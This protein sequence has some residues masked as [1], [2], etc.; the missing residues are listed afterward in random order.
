MST[1]LA[2]G[3][4]ILA[5]GGEKPVPFQQ[6]IC[7]SQALEP[8]IAGTFTRDAMKALVD[9]VGCNTEDLQSPATIA[10]L[11]QLDTQTLLNAS[12]ATYQSDIAHNIGD[13]WLPAIDGD[14]LPAAPSQLV[15]EHRFAK[16]V[17]TMMGWCEDDL[18]FFTDASIQ[19]AEDTRNFISMY[20]GGVT[21]AN[22]DTL[23]DLYPVSDFAAGPGSDPDKTLSAEFYRAARIFRDILMVCEPLWYGEH[24]AEAGSKVYFYDWNQTMLEPILESLTGVSGYGPIHTSEFA[25]IFGNLSHYDANGY[26]FH[27]TEADYKLRDRGSRS[28]TTFA[29]TGKPGLCVKDTFEGFKPAFRGGDNDPGLFVVGGPHEGFSQVDGPGSHE[30]VRRQRLRERCAF[31]NSPEMIEQLGV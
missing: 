11:R 2:V 3:L 26:P 12:I 7:E 28:W 14:F 6:G 18:T 24:L 31:I 29:S 10:C 23:L 30:Q 15:R 16:D 22:I 8:G 17:T 5:Y 9:A 1:G 21:K 20:A 25:Y 13:I 4:H 19:T 27:P